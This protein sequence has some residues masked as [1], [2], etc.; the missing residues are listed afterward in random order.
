MMH[1]E[2]PSLSPRIRRLVNRVQRLVS[3]CGNCQPRDSGE[4]IWV[5]GDE[6]ALSDLL[7][8]EGVPAHNAAEVAN[9]LTCLNCGSAQELGNDVGLKDA[10]ELERDARELEWRRQHE[11]RLNGLIDEMVTSPYLVL[12]NAYARKIQREIGS[13]P[14]VGI[15]TPRWFRARSPDREKPSRVMTAEDLGPPTRA[16]TI[17]EGRFNHAGQCVYYLSASPTAAGLEVLQDIESG[18]VWIAEVDI[19]GELK[20]LDSLGQQRIAEVGVTELTL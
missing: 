20:L 4:R 9:A 6:C 1:D 10:D 7:D 15:P 13:F 12:S 8:Q 19:R 3:Y 17:A 11:P 14:T 18:L 5:L 16:P 2:E